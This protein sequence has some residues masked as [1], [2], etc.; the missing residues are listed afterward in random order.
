VIGFLDEAHPQNKA[1]SGRFWSFGKH[2][3]KENTT[4]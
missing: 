4:K 2:I 1:N 3:M